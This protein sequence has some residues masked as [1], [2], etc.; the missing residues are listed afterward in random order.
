M[1]DGYLHYQELKGWHDAPF[2]QPS[3][4]DAQF[5][6]H[7]LGQVVESGALVAEVGFGNGNFLG[8]AAAR[9]A[10]VFGSEVQ[11]AARDKALHAGVGLLPLDFGT[12][13]GAL[14]GRLR[15]IAAIDVME[16]LTR[17]QNA[18]LLAAA[19]RLLEP[20][21]LLFLR[22]PN[23][24]SPLSLPIQYG[25]QTHVSVLSAPIVEQ[26]ARGLALDVVFAGRPF[27]PFA[28]GAAGR[29]ARKIQDLVR[30][31][32]DRL[33]RLIYGPLPM[34][35]NTVMVLRRR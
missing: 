25:D 14:P 21:G 24:Q 4:T 10:R 1:E 15:V 5:F 32:C 13:Q 6:T 8:W 22:F 26:M 16:H 28:G 7:Y 2:M 29:A 23:G 34:H 33:I 30:G 12:W 31:A 35:A 18:G 11:A 19:A 27:R 3:A 17:D 9:G 20:G